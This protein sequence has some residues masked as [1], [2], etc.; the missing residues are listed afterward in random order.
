MI[1]FAIFIL[2]GVIGSS[3]SEE[4]TITKEEIEQYA[5]LMEQSGAALDQCA[6]DRVELARVFKS[7]KDQIALKCEEGAILRVTDPNGKKHVFYC[8]KAIEI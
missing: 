5:S 6:V 3:L 4:P 8:S 7:F 1:V 2:A